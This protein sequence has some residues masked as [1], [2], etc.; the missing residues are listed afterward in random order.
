MLRGKTQSCLFCIMQERKKGARI[1]GPSRRRFL[2]A[3]ESGLCQ[4][5]DTPQS[6]WIRNSGYIIIVSGARP[7]QHARKRPQR[8]G[9]KR[10][11]VSYG[12]STRKDELGASAHF[13]PLRLPPPPPAPPPP[14]PPP[15]TL[16]PPQASAVPLPVPVCPPPPPCR[17]P[18]VRCRLRSSWS[19]SS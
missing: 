4:A 5:Q 18:R 14:P 8:R 10:A 13:V 2:S 7:T 19:R 1:V 15:V 3:G 6:C 9:A 16:R 11:R 17:R 12:D